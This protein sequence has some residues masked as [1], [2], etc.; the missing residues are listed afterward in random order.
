M[1]YQ[2]TK[3]VEMMISA[4]HYKLEGNIALLSRKTRNQNSHHACATL[5]YKPP[6]YLSIGW[7]VF[8]LCSSQWPPCSP[9][10]INLHTS[11][12]I[13]TTSRVANKNNDKTT[14]T[15]H[16]LSYFCDALLKIHAN[17]G[18][19]FREVHLQSLRSLKHGASWRLSLQ[20][21]RCFISVLGWFDRKF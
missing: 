12:P 9:L 21:S 2:L 7:F 8:N 13:R 10:F 1:V 11:C 20:F 4:K 14:S 18:S 17:G 19:G 6:A 15:C 3:P 5:D 16:R